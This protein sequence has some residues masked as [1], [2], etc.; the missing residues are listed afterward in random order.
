MHPSNIETR[1][2]VFDVIDNN[3]ITRYIKQIV[4]I[5]IVS[6]I[7]IIRLSFREISL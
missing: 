4:S 2:C 3:D 6:L 1:D 7:D 5:N